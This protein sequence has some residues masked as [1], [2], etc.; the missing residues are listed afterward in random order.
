MPVNPV[1]KRSRQKSGHVG[2][3]LN[4]IARFESNLPVK[5]RSCLKI[6]FELTTE[7]CTHTN[8]SRLHR[9]TPHIKRNKLMR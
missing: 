9:F 3:Y 7:K 6:N 8:T 5:V 4:Y 2:D 1:P